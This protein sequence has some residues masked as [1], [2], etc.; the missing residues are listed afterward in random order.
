MK[1]D[2]GLSKLLWCVIT[3]SPNMEVNE[4]SATSALTWLS[5]LLSPSSTLWVLSDGLTLSPSCTM[6]A[7]ENLPCVAVW[8]RVRTV[9]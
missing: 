8:E 4:S 1:R 3:G 9:K 6:S 2:V 7:G 5:S